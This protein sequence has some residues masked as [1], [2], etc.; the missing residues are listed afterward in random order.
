[1]STRK[2]FSLLGNLSHALEV[3]V[4]TVISSITHMGNSTQSPWNFQLLQN[5]GQG[6][7]HERLGK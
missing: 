3:M 4:F 7:Y 2:Y 6:Q 5:F 1:M